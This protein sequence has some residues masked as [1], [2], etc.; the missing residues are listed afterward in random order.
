M[1]IPCDQCGVEEYMPYVCKF[2]KGRFCA[3]HRLPENHECQ[4]LGAYKERIRKE[5]RIVRPDPDVMSPR[6]SP[7]ARATMGFS[8]ASTR[9]NELWSRVDGKMAYVF[10]GIAV[11]TFVMQLSLLSAGN[12][13]L[14]S[15]L[16][17]INTGFWLEPWTIVTN[18]FA[19]GG[20]N[21]ILINMLILFFFGPTVERLI[22]TKRFTYL[23]L[24]TGAVAG[25]AQILG[26][27]LME[28]GRIHGALGASGAIQGILGT[29]V[30]LAPR[31]T[32][33]VM[34]IIPAPLWAVTILFA[35]Y[36]LFYNVL[37]GSGVGGIAHLT[38][39]ALGIAYG[40][41]L[42]KQGLRVNVPRE[43]SM[44]KRYF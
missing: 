34:F 43:P 15:R 9:M 17:V 36:D 21:H 32:V 20:L 28:P 7:G 41:H 22:G 14:H 29:L 3:A 1:P 2:C 38:G 39:L 40:L 10:M 11:A 24:V 23:F 4:G 44:M 13:A 18:V 37:P 8:R 27:M 35:L 30:I 31:L 16:F 5:G 26:G 33:Y 19:H 12:A 25:I 6:M 42:H